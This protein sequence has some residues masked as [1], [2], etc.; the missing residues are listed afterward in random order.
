MPLIL[1]I[2]A[3]LS[4]TIFFLVAHSLLNRIRNAMTT[5]SSSALLNCVRALKNDRSF[6]SFTKLDDLR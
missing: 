5:D 1:I 4:I 2:M 3:L 6:L